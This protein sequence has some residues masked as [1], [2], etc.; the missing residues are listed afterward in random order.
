[1]LK[2]NNIINSQ[3]YYHIHKIGIYEEFWQVGNFIETSQNE[4]TRFSFN[5]SAKINFTIKKMF[6]LLRQL[7][8]LKIR[9]MCMNNCC[10]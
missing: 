1:M 10:Y 3:I 5:L 4:F 8:M 6:Q 9:I 2:K 7:I